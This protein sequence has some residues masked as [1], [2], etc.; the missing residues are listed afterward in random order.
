MPPQN[1]VEGFKPSCGEEAVTLKASSHPDF[2]SR[3]CSVA[4]GA[5]REV[6]SLPRERGHNPSGSWASA[7]R[8]QG[9][10]M[11]CVVCF[12]KPLPPRP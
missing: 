7:A 1:T 6:R 11:K 9:V 10:G 4:P 12:S 5:P 8:R 2:A 3:K